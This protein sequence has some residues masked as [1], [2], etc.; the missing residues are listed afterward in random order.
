MAIAVNSIFPELQF[1]KGSPVI[2]PVFM[3]CFCPICDLEYDPETVRR[4]L[5]CGWDLTPLPGSPRSP[6]YRAFLDKQQQQIHWA[7]KLWVR[8]RVGREYRQ[9][10]RDR[11]SQTDYITAI[12]RLEAKIDRLD[13]AVEASHRERSEIKQQ[14][15]QLLA[16]FDRQSF[17]EI[18]AQLSQIYQHFN[19]E[20]E[21]DEPEHPYPSS[22]VGIDYTEL[23]NL[24]A[25]GEWQ[26]A[27]E[28][29]RSLML[30]AGDRQKKGYLNC[31]DLEYFP[32]MDLGTLDWAWQTYSYGRFGLRVQRTVWQ[33]VG[34]DYTAFCDR[35]GWRDR[36]NWLY[37]DEVDFSLEAPPGHLP[38]FAWQQ[39]ACY[40]T[41]EVTAAELLEAAIAR[42]ND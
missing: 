20:T 13:R 35:V 22:E 33:E 3:P 41:G 9:E 21:A 6:L 7:I 34:G 19:S 29:T 1:G 17:D 11:P 18:K 16:T 15:Q 2:C 40:G 12:A 8:D 37:Y 5:G 30:T 32:S 28:M 27:D 24:L 36:E 4:C 42:F 25:A 14:L 31:E 10:Y 38:I 26:Q 23:L 39:R